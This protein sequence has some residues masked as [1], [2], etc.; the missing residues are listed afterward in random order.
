[1][2]AG[3]RGLGG[4]EMSRY[5]DL[6]D[7]DEVADPAPTP[8]TDEEREALMQ[9]NLAAMDEWERAFGPFREPQF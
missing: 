5:N 7:V 2:L 1:M 4:V 3:W 9:A 6:T 8:A